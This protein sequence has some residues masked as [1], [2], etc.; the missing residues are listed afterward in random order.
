MARAAKTK[1]KP[2]QPT[3]RTKRSPFVPCAIRNESGDCYRSAQVE[4]GHNNLPDDGGDRL[5]S[6]LGSRV[7]CREP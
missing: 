5:A 6:T 4:A 2:A 1:T 3:R 7:P